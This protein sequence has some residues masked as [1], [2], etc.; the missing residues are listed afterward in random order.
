MSNRI[1]R[2]LQDIFSPRI[3]ILGVEKI[4]GVEPLYPLDHTPIGTCE[5]CGGFFRPEKLTPAYVGTF[6]FARELPTFKLAYYCQ[7]CR[8]AAAFTLNLV[9]DDGD[10]LDTLHFDIGDGYFQQ[11]DVDTGED[12]AVLSLEEFSHTFCMECGEL[13][14]EQTCQKHRPKGGKKS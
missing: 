11:K 12:N 10:V 1:T 2:F 8:P 14:E 3:E 5:K 4:T 13:I 6:V 9:D 7:S